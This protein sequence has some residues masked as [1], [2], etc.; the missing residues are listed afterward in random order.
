M[1]IFSPV[2]EYM[3]MHA[4]SQHSTSFVE[5]AGP[6]MC[7]MCLVQRAIGNWPCSGDSSAAC[8]AKLT[9][10]TDRTPDLNFHLDMLGSWDILGCC[11]WAARPPEVQLAL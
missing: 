4:S 11:R 5:F 1:L 10:D 6:A 2:G 8:A 9:L 3:G 7:S